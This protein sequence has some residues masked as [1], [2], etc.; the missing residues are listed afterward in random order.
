MHNGAEH[1]QLQ[2]LYMHY[3]IIKK[4]VHLSVPEMH[5]IDEYTR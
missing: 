2:S 1:K 3:V 4:P 5:V